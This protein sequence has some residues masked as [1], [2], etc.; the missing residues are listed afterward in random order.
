MWEACGVPTESLAEGAKAANDVD[1]IPERGECP[2]A[3]DGGNRA[4][5]GT[6]GKEKERQ[7]P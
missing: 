5:A 1:G 2:R 6:N 7:R 4:P 3:R